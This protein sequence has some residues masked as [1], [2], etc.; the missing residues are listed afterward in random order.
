MTRDRTEIFN[1]PTV[2]KQHSK[3]GQASGQ[4]PQSVSLL[5]PLGTA[6]FLERKRERKRHLPRGGESKA[7]ETRNRHSPT[8]RNRYSPRGWKTDGCFFRVEK[9]SFT[10]R[11]GKHFKNGGCK[12][13]F[14]SW[15][16]WNRLGLFYW[17][18]VSRVRAYAEN[19]IFLIP[20][21]F[22]G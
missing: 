16:E 21:N 2:R 4:P 5:H 3:Q 10:Q 8:S 18:C 20:H 13:T 12:S 7:S 9:P 15:S 17:A 22:R 6:V 1:N 11:A 19:L 14:K